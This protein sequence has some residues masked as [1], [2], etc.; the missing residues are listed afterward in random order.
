MHLKQKLENYATHHG[1]NANLVNVNISGSNV[2]TTDA[3]INN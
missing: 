3:G 1:V 2:D